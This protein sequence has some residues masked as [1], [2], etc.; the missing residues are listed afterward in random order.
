MQKN[1]LGNTDILVSEICLGT[2]TWGRQNTEAE[3]FEQMD[4]AVEQGVNFF[5]TA[6]LY[7]IPPEAETQGRTETMI[8]NWFAARGNRDKIILATKV[9]GR[10]KMP[11]FRDNGAP[12]ELSEEQIHEAIDKSLERLQTD[13]IDLYQLHWP[14]RPINLFGGQGYTHHSDEINRIEDTLGVLD[15]LVK[16]GKIRTIG[17]SNET[18]W[19]IMK[20]LHYAQVN[21]QSQ[22]VSVQNAYN[23]LNRIYEYGSSEIYHREGIGLLAYSPIAQGYLSGKYLNGA[24]PPGSR[25]SIADRLQ[26]YETPGA[27]EA[28]VKY[29]A[30][31]KKYNLDPSQMANK[32]VTSRPFV[33]SN[34]IGATTMEQLRLAIG[35]NDISLSDEIMEEIEA[36]HIRAPNLC[37]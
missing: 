37:P 9:T 17:L 26:R 8:G 4:Y 7:P 2:M 36:V 30:I 35:S 6:E 31:A 25:K 14:D 5:D 24:I 10:S 22:I 19:G 29:L 1:K 33:T 16:A 18:P 20:F 3:A 27:E 15:G 11:W 13:Y 23:L 12:T 32:F 28:I 34:I 21:A